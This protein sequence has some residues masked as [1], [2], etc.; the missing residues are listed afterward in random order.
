[1]TAD[2][3]P[4][5]LAVIVTMC[6]AHIAS[7]TG[8]AVF[9]SLLPTLQPLWDLSSTQAGWIN[10]IYFAGYVSAV[11]VMVSL[12]DRVDARYV[13]LAGL[14]LGAIGLAGFAMAADGFWSALLWHALQGAGV[15]SSYM[16]GLKVMTDRLPKPAP[17]RAIAIYAANFSVGAALSFLLAGALGNGPG[18]QWAFGVAAFGPVCA[19]LLVLTLLRPRPPEPAERPATG[20][21]DFRPVFRNRTA[22]GYVLGYAGHSWELF[23]LRGWIVTFLVFAG[24]GGAA[25]TGSGETGLLGATAIAAAVNIAGVPSTIFGNELAQRFGRRRVIV[26][27]MTISTLVSW[28]V[29]FSPSLSATVVIALTF[30]YGIAIMGD[31]GSLTAGAAG[32]AEPGYGGAT[33]AVHS[34]LG[35][36]GGFLGPLAVG[37]VLDLP[38]GQAS[39]LAWGL[40]FATM[41]F[42]SAAGAVAL[43]WVTRR[44]GGAAG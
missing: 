23:A 22:M 34:M 7:M 38:G 42:G 12:T 5:P 43:L 15:G 30:V 25:G 24:V 13:Y 44:R 28:A 36:G 14:A 40:A 4:R 16:T 11:P 8:F 10:G 19:A 31:S 37:L 2:R 41:G 17:S 35:F 20:L 1:M 9:P 26:T 39:T 6:A 21:L 3:P 18:W 33:L 32:S 27:V 29:G